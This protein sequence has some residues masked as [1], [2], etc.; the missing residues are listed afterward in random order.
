[1]W[2][3]VGAIASKPTGAMDLVIKEPDLVCKDRLVIF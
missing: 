2:E 1:M 3:K